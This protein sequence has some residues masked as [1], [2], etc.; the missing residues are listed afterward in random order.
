M[1]LFD[2]KPAQGSTKKSKRK[3]RGWG[4]GK[5][6]TA[7]R[8]YNGQGQRSGSEVRPGFEGGQMPLFRRLPKKKYFHVVNKINYG[9]INVKD[10]NKYAEGTLVNLELL[11]KDRLVDK[12]SQ[13]LRV[14]GNGE[15]S[16]KLRVEA[17][18]FSE[19]AK[20]KIS[21]LGGEA[22]VIEG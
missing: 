7:G 8:G 9:I 1:K 5:G 21:S 17:N 20:E 18:H 11:L 6:K 4:S 22:I 14:L 12:H 10:L 19:S 2:L 3:G 13:A 15:L 16:V